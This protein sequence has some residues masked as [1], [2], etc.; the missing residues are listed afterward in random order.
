MSSNGNRVENYCVSIAPVRNGE[1]LVA[2][3]RV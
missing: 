1:A 3:A 2:T